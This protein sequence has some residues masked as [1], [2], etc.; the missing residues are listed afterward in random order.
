MIPQYNKTMA[1]WSLDGGFEKSEIV[2]G[3]LIFQGARYA[4]IIH[5]TGIVS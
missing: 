2:I 1:A 5:H 3:H 4:F